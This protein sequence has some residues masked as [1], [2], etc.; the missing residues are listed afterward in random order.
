MMDRERAPEDIAA[1]WA[2]LEAQAAGIADPE[3]RAQ[4]LGVWRA[5]FDREVS[6]LPQVAAGESLHAV[7]NAEPD[8]VTGEFPDYAFP[9]EES[10]SAARLI[11][12]VRA[13]L[14]KR[15]ERRAIT[16]EL[17]D[18]MKMAEAI[19]FVKREITAVLRDIESDLKHG[20][21]VREDAEMVRVLYRRTLGLRGPMNE[22]MLPQLIDGRAARAPSAAA[23]KRSKVAA[24]IDAR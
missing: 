6:S 13:A 19:G 23:V 4:F 11:T 17:A 8:P 15:A 12:I 5:R 21:A 18:L 20:S 9:A 24:L 22:A 10:D 7:I 16:E 2:N 3:T 14:A 1:V